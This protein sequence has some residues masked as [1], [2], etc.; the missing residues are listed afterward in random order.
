[1]YT[2][3]VNLLLA[4]GATHSTT[5][6]DKALNSTI[7]TVH[8]S[9]Q[10]VSQW[11]LLQKDLADTMRD[12]MRPVYDWCIDET[13]VPAS[14]PPLAAP[15]PPPFA[16]WNAEAHSSSALLPSLTPEPPPASFAPLLPKRVPLP[17]PASRPQPS[18]VISGW[19]RWRFASPTTPPTSSISSANIHPSTSTHDS[20]LGPV[21]MPHVASSSSRFIGPRLPSSPIDSFNGT[22][23]PVPGYTCS[24]GD[25]PPK[26]RYIWT[27]RPQCPFNSGNL[28]GFIVCPMPVGLSE[29][30]FIFLDPPGDPRD[31]IVDLGPALDSIPLHFES[32][33]IPYHRPLQH[34]TSFCDSIWLKVGGVALTLVFIYVLYLGL[35]IVTGYNSG[36]SSINEPTETIPPQCPP[37]RRAPARTIEPQANATDIDATRISYF[38]T[39]KGT[40]NGFFSG[41]A[42]I[43]I[44]PCRSVA[45]ITSSCLTEITRVFLELWN[46]L[47]RIVKSL[48]ARVI[49]TIISLWKSAR[50]VVH[51]VF[52]TTSRPVLG[53][54]ALTGN[55]VK[56]LFKMIKDVFA[57]MAKPRLPPR[58]V[59]EQP[60]SP[61]VQHTPP[62]VTQRQVTQQ[63]ARMSTTNSANAQTTDQ[64]EPRPS[65][66]RSS[67]VHPSLP[68]GVA[69]AIRA[70]N[71]P[72]LV[73]RAGGRRVNMA[74]PVR[75]TASASG[76]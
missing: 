66:S 64:P 23:L 11:D 42:F 59:D 48:F 34:T 3:W 1:M 38:D 49:N 12:I 41:V 76:S 45:Q 60:T 72:P 57:Y 39:M 51:W 63:A 58:R 53:A 9:F 54:Y 6:V 50:K 25:R 37:R 30:K 13:L 61:I 32:L 31:P 44:F 36:N 15:T 56:G 71:A 22:E 20:R 65:T 43:I 73:R 40:V 26:P 2:T 27:R 29:Y 70:G 21:A 8:A 10:S 35:S 74:R 75:A 55:I 14:I 28:P 4:S 52:V 16:F 69:D 18:V 46:L 67:N 17:I 68:P 19:G 62:S 33:L 7:H 5:A 47:A 24:P